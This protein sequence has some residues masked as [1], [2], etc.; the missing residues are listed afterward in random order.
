MRPIWNYTALTFLAITAI[1]LN[2][3]SGWLDDGFASPNYAAGGGE[4]LKLPI[5]ARTAGLATAT[6][7]WRDHLSGFQYNPAILD[8]ADSIIVIAT[9]SFLTLDRSH[10]GFDLASGIGEFLVAGLSF[11][12]FGVGNIEGRDEFGGL[13]E[14]FSAGFN[15]LSATVAGRLAIPVSFG[16]RGRYLFESIENERSN[17]MGFDLG[18]TWQPL[19]R[20][21]IGMSAQNIG[22]YIWWSTSTRDQVLM[23]GRFGVCASLLNNTLRLELDGIKTLTQ[24]EE[25]AFG[26]EYNFAG[27]LYGR[28][29]FRS[30]VSPRER[31]AM[32]PEYS[33]GAGMRYE[34]LGFDYAL[35][36]P[37]SELG[38]IHKVSIAGKLPGF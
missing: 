25:A 8:A 30:S 19:E 26:A 9:T 3:F 15:A 33:F 11:S 37:P 17:G 35:V 4:Y 18:A 36:V 24:P 32:K 31:S 34:F 16:A 2:S 10:Y 27:I 6:V 13:T 5:H 23:T 29:G 14:S 1:A 38:L 12:Q 20:L 21:C 22:S 7:A 28:G